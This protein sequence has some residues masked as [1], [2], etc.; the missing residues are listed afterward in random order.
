[1]GVCHSRNRPDPAVTTPQ[2]VESIKVCDETLEDALLSIPEINYGT[3]NRVSLEWE[4]LGRLIPYNTDGDQP[5]SSNKDASEFHSLRRQLTTTKQRG[6]FTKPDDEG[7]GKAVQRQAT[8]GQGTQSIDQFKRAIDMWTNFKVSGKSLQNLHGVTDAWSYV[9]QDHVPLPQELFASNGRNSI[10]EDQDGEDAPTNRGSRLDTTSLFSG[11]GDIGPFSSRSSINK[12]QSVSIGSESL[13]IGTI[14][15]T[16]TGQSD[17]NDS[18]EPEALLSN[19]E[20]ALDWLNYELVF[21]PYVNANS[22]HAYTC[23]YRPRREDSPRDKS[24]EIDDDILQLLGDLLDPFQLRPENNRRLKMLE[25]IRQLQDT[26]GLE[27]NFQEYGSFDLDGQPLHSL[28]RKPKR[29][30]RRSMD[31]RTLSTISDTR[32]GYNERGVGLPDECWEKLEAANNDICC[33]VRHNTPNPQNRTSTASKQSVQGRLVD[34]SDI[35]LLL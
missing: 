35:P 1:M 23:I 25:I 33:R 2:K 24:Y 28:L 5:G 11:N 34:M 32:C 26:E 22:K 21:R 31:L 7:A 27:T 17:R 18:I 16:S 20:P 30:V 13:S 3:F 9:D 12:T 10:E 19:A 29:V 14:G 4:T 6:Y 8:G 15:R